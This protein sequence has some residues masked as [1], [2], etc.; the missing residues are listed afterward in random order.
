MT[1]PLTII[2]TIIFVFL[3]LMCPSVDNNARE[4][5]NVAYGVY[6]NDRED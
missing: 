1:R 6:I 4:C 5:D 3:V 2:L